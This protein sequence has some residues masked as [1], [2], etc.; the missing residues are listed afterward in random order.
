MCKCCWVLFKNR[1]LLSISLISIIIPTYNRAHLIRETLTSL[2]NQTYTNWECII[3]DD[4]SSDNIETVINE[5]IKTN[6]KFQFYKRPDRKPKGANACRNYGYEKS[7][8]EYINWFDSDD[9]MHPDFLMNRYKKLQ[10]NSALDFCSCISSTFNKD[11]NTPIDIESPKVLNSN[12]Y[13]EDYLLNGLYFYTPSPL[14]KKTFLNNKTLFDETLHRSQERDFHFRMLVHNPKYVYIENVLFYVRV[15]DDSI[16]TKA[17]LSLK[18]QKSVFRYFDKVFNSINE[19]KNLS[20]KKKLLEYVFYRQATLFYNLYGLANNSKER[21]EI[22]SAYSKKILTYVL[23]MKGPFKII[24][25]LLFGIFLLV[26]FNKGYAY[27]YYPK[28]NTRSYNE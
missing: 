12:N 25:K 20:N 15:G 6:S 21:K 26:C 18:A 23:K 9:I 3:V 13:I 4:G 2:I 1:K 10:E 5:Y 8:G 11:I 16:T 22:I 24:F 19:N 14:W 28:Y 27:F 17:S 7:K